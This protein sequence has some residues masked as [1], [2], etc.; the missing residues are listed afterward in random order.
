MIDEQIFEDWQTSLKT[1]YGESK[2]VSERLLDAMAKESD[3]PVVVCRVGQVAGPVSECGIWP[4]QEW[5][6]S[7]IAS[8]K[9]LG[10]L[11]SSIG[12]MKTV[13]W[14]PVDMLANIIVELAIHSPDTPKAG[15]T[16]Y[17]AVNPQRASW[18]MLV[19][20][21]AQCDTVSWDDWIGALR[22][23]GSKKEDVARNPAVKILDFF[24]SLCSEGY[25]PTHFD[26]RETVRVSRTLA[27]LGPVH[28]GW[29]KIWMRQWSF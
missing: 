4:K 25:E 28:E 21:I 5:L 9:Y 8:S 1:G 26:T 22:E 27:N 14:I 13:D 11:P 10:K 6:P 29:I 12:R 17:H 20:T 18:A 23:S 15:A 16:V 19:S 7:L 24:D 3:I 2:F